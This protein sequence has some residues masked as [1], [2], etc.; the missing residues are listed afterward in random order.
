[1]GDYCPR[2]LYEL[3]LS[4]LCADLPSAE[5][6]NRLP[7]NAKCHILSICTK[8]GRISSELLQCLLNPRVLKLELSACEVSDQH[9]ELLFLCPNVTKLNLNSLKGNRSDITSR[10]ITQVSKYCENIRE[11]QLRRCTAI[12]DWG[13]VKVLLKCQ[14][15]TVLNLSGC[16]SLTDTTLHAVA[17]NSTRLVSVDLSRNEN[18][19]DEGV[20]CI[21]R[22][23]QQTLQEVCINYCTKLTDDSVYAL[24]TFCTKL[25]IM[26]FAGCVSMTSDAQELAN[27]LYSNKPCKLLSYTI[28]F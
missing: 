26:T 15:L 14:Y 24:T 11:L 3:T 13:M 4:V 9:L 27:N 2:K 18:F 6:L 28:E 1:M 17:N 16:V 20:T 22:N 7:N 23:L 10:G 5:K 19:T 25:D 21:A 12:C 8:R